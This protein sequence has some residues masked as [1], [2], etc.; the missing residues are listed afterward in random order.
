[1][2]SVARPFEHGMFDKSYKDGAISV[3]MRGRGRCKY[4]NMSTFLAF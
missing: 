1:M 4:V 3:A 2:A